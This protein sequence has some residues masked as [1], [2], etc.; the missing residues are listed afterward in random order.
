M[1]ENQRANKTRAGFTFQDLAAIVLF[2]DNF[3]ELKSIKAEGNKE[4]ID[5]ELLDG[6]WIYA[7]AKMITDPINSKKAYRRRR[8]SESFT[9]L[10]NNLFKSEQL[11]L[12]LSIFRT[13][14]I[15]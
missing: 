2:I 11:F 1:V 13:V 5:V 7:Q 8:M 4:D 3:D 6:S 15:Q 9:S 14:K 10:C 12:I